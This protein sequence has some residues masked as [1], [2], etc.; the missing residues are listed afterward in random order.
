MTADRTLPRVRAAGGPV[1]VSDARAV[2]WWF[3]TPQPTSGL[4]LLPMADERMAGA[5]HVPRTADALALALRSRYPAVA[6]PDLTGWVA[7]LPGTSAGELLD[8]LAGAVLPGG[9]LYVGMRMRPGPCGRTRLSRAKAVG[10][11]RALGLDDLQAWFPLP[12]VRC[13]AFLVPADRGAELEHFL[14]TLFFP[15]SQ[16]RSAWRGR[17]RQLLLSAARRAA[18]RTPHRWRLRCAPG[19][20]LL[21]RRPP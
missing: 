12:S 3:L 20:A 16:D 14:N 4:L 7:D 11:L 21:A 18:L 10:R 2:N 19:L 8:Q 13:P 15:Y 1:A 6:A 5:V 17:A 9:W